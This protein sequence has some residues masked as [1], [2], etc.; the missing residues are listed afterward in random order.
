MR[1]VWRQ[2]EFHTG[3]SFIYVLTRDTFL[4]RKTKLEVMQLSY[5]HEYHYTYWKKRHLNLLVVKADR[6]PHA[7]TDTPG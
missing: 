6:L 5:Y 3:N 7:V 1:C 4:I 2:S